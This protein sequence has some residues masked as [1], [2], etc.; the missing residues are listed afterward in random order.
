MFYT[1]IAILQVTEL[2]LAKHGLS[3]AELV[4]SCVTALLVIFVVVYMTRG[5]RED[6]KECAE[7]IKASSAAIVKAIDDA[8]SRNDVA[9]AKVQVETQNA[10]NK[11]AALQLE[12]TRIG[13]VANGPRT[14]PH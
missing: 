9:V 8:A 6:R 11:V 1:V 10:A 7:S 5:A 13:A 3:L 2:E 4:P 12:I 14:S